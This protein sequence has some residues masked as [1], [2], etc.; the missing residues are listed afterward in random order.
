M[1]LIAVA[2]RCSARY[3][4]VLAAN[5]DEL[6]DRPA[7][8]AAAWLDSPDIRGGRDLAAGG[9]W[10][11]LS[12]RGRLAAV[13]NLRRGERA[14]APH[15]RGELVRDFLLADDPAP[16]AAAAGLARAGDYG[17]YNL[18]LWDG[19]A[20]VHATNRPAP[21]CATLATGVHGLSNGP[22]DARWPKV[23]RLTNRL[24]DWLEA[25]PEAREPA[26]APLFAALSDEQGA[27][28]DELPDTGLGIDVE[29][30]LAPAFIRNRHYGTRASTVVL[31]DRD[32]RAQLL[33]RS[34]APDGEPTADVRLDFSLQA[35]A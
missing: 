17:P 15:S 16:A 1:C 34:F 20:L 2:W 26:V 32:G 18:L 12:G 35:A 29:R 31:I 22:I 10:L 21:A 23:R 24:R 11:A 6:H 25:L 7:L 14:A 13:T 4:L 8:M 19:Q 9:S 33:E 5:R 27:P 3:P 30:R 28:D